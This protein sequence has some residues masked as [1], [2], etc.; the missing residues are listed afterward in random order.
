MMHITLLIYRNTHL[1]I[2]IFEKMNE[3]S[4]TVRGF[5]WPKKG[6]G[7]LLWRFILTYFP[8]RGGPRISQRRS[9][10]G[11]MLANSHAQPCRPKA[12]LVQCCYAI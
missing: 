11:P 6:E 10:T 4:S 1:Y 9:D 12:T 3:K 5:F 2:L 7:R 8:T